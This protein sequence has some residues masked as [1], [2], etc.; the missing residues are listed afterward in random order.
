MY[1]CTLLNHNY[2]CIFQV[3]LP[4]Y[5]YHQHR[6]ETEHQDSKLV[7]KHA[8]II[9]DHPYAVSLLEKMLT[10]NPNTR[11]TVSQRPTNSSI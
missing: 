11:I 2:I 10:L 6:F 3:H 9:G 4:D 1:V 7:E 5:H 8:P